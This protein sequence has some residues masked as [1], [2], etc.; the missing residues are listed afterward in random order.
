MEFP[1][2]YPE[3]ILAGI[4]CNRNN[5]VK[6]AENCSETPSLF[7]KNH[8][9]ISVLA[10]GSGISIPGLGIPDTPVTNVV[11]L[12]FNPNDLLR[13]TVNEDAL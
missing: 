2:A 3:A 9:I 10:F 6:V 1:K 12:K 4:P 7:V 5:M 11:T 13:R 8:S